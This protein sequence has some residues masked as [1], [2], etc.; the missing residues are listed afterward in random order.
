M[1]F[2]YI[3]K[4]DEKLRK[5]IYNYIALSI[6]ELGEDKVWQII[7]TIKDAKLRLEIRQIYY[8]ILSR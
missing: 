6:L 4:I 5:I 3:R 2:D 8:D 7:E 1:D